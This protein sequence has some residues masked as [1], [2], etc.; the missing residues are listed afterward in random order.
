MILSCIYREI[1]P[2]TR[3]YPKCELQ[4]VFLHK[5]TVPSNTVTLEVDKVGA[6]LPEHQK[7]RRD[8]VFIG[9]MFYKIQQSYILQQLTFELPSGRSPIPERNT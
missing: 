1:T 5:K 8:G 2:I 9:Q 7:G 3:S 4:G 6:W